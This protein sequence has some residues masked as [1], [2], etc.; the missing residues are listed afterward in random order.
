ML[1]SL[2]AAKAAGVGHVVLLS[3][4]GAEH[5]T[6]VPHHALEVWL[7]D[8]GLSWTFVR[9][10]FFMQ[11]ITTTHLSDVRAAARSWSPRVTVPPRSST[12]ATSPPKHSSTPNITTTQRGPQPGRKR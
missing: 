11:N 4:Q 2:E 12:S 6:V 8:S 7:R 9:A 3:L 10:A 5:N 1:P